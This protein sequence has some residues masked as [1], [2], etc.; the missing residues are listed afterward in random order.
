MLGFYFLFMGIVPTVPYIF[1]SNRK[2]FYKDRKIAVCKHNGCLDTS[3]INYG[4]FDFI[5]R[6][7]P[8]KLIGGLYYG[9][10]LLVKQNNRIVLWNYYLNRVMGYSSD[11]RRNTK[12]TLLKASVMF[13]L[14]Y[15]RLYFRVSGAGLANKEI[16]PVIFFKLKGFFFF[17]LIGSLLSKLRSYFPSLFNGNF[18]VFIK[19]YNLH[20]FHRLW[21]KKKS[22]KKIKMKEAFTKNKEVMLYS[23]TSILS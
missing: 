16:I 18:L 23:K 15:F 2:F 12:D 1:K 3:V 14:S 5:L 20:N 8:T 7:S 9:Q 6:A 17:N 21:K 10:G 19:F 11:K 13:F 4:L 22:I